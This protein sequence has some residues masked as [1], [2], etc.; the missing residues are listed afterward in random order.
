MFLECGLPS[1]LRELFVMAVFVRPITIG[2]DYDSWGQ[3]FPLSPQ[4]RIS[5]FE[6][7]VV[8][9]LEL[10]VE[11]AL[12]PIGP[13]GVVLDDLLEVVEKLT[14]GVNTSDLHVGSCMPNE[15]ALKEWD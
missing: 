8:S 5:D 11:V 13:F 14:I 2:K 9:I 10:I 6:V 3:S 12:E 15:C 4:F 7:D 1:P